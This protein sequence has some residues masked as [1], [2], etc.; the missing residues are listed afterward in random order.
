MIFSKKPNY[1]AQPII[2][3]HKSNPIKEVRNVGDINN[4]VFGYHPKVTIT[5]FMMNP[6]INSSLLKNLI[7]KAQPEKDHSPSH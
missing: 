2:A 4:M 3:V 7:F 6:S 5:S 1:Y